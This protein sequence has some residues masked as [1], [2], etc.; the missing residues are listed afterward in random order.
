MGCFVGLLGFG[1]LVVGVFG[2]G[3]GNRALVILSAVMLLSCLI[4]CV[5]DTLLMSYKREKPSRAPI[6][7]GSH[8]ALKN[9][10]RGESEHPAYKCDLEQ[11]IQRARELHMRFKPSASLG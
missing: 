1:S 8:G 11:K 6:G 10:P 5:V 3:L 4:F 2:L 7:W 9:R